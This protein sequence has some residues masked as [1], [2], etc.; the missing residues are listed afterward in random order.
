MKGKSMLGVITPTIVGPFQFKNFVTKNIPTKFTF[1][2]SC[3]LNSNCEKNQPPISNCYH[4]QIPKSI[5]FCEAH[6]I[7]TKRAMGNS[8]WKIK[9]S[10]KRIPTFAIFPTSH[11]EILN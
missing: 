3:M 5:Y 1:D 10:W 9:S 11:F 6:F 4:L 2:M 8:S 7:Q